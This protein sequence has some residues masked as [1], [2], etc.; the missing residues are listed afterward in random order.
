M[1]SDQIR[2][3]CLVGTNPSILTINRNTISR[4]F[5][6]CCCLIICCVL[7]EQPRNGLPS[8]YRLDTRIGEYLEFEWNL[9]RTVIM[10]GWVFTDITP[11]YLTNNHKHQ[12]HQSN[13]TELNV[14]ERNEQRKQSRT[15]CRYLQFCWAIFFFFLLCSLS[16]ARNQCMRY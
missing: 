6:A 16:F 9:F 4:C 2:L 14:S 10:C 13:W 3:H 7:I 5:C 1:K 11:T 15:V 12:P 8:T